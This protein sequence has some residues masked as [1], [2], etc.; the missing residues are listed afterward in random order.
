L[1]GAP[2]T[3]SKIRI[4]NNLLP[5]IPDSKEKDKGVSN[6]NNYPDK[7]YFYKPVTNEF[8]Y[9][10]IANEDITGTRNYYEG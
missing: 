3:Y 9:S 2:W 8:S 1:A 5:D 4:N 7:Y 10:I 6:I